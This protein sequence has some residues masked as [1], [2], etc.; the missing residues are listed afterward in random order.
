ME[1]KIVKKP[2]NTDKFEIQ[3]NANHIFVENHNF[4]IPPHYR[5]H[6]PYHKLKDRV[7]TLATKGKNLNN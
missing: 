3:I 5:D 7:I 4:F 2:Q 1:R 6:P